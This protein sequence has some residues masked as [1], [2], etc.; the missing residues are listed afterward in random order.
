MSLSTDAF[1]VPQEFLDTARALNAD[2]LHWLLSGG[3]DHALAACFPPDVELPM[4]WSV[5]GRVTDGEGVLVDDAPW[6]GPTGW[7]SFG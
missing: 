4:A 2:P 7:E 6:T 1:H 5:V 3:D